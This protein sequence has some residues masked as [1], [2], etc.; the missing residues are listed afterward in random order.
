MVIWGEVLTRP[1]HVKNGT[2]NVSVN[3][4]AAFVQKKK[5]RVAYFTEKATPLK[6]KKN[7]QISF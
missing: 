1:P 3:C 7:W 2:S 5:K 6:M 4:N